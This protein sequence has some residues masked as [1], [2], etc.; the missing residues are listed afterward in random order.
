MNMGEAR[1]FFTKAERIADEHGLHLLARTISSEHD[2]LLE[3][4]EK[5]ETLRKANPPVAERVKFVEIEKTLDHMMGKK[6]LEPPD[7]VEENPILLLIM[8]EGGHTFFNHTFIK[9]WDYSTL[10][11]SFI[12]A[13]NTF[14]S[15]IFEETID[16]IKIGENIIFIKPVEP[17]VVCYV[18]NGQSYPAVKKL[19]NFSK[20]IKN[21]EEI[22]AILNKAAKATQ[23]L[24][25][26]SS[27]LLGAIV[28]EIFK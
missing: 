25:V 28:N 9:D 2:L 16:R 6:M 3:Q 12:S 24:S 22:W 13:F 15:E 17:F 26:S 19:N 14:S 20:L 5:W 23:E 21:R 4:L 11:S 8:S 7:L 27:P 18:S 10:F 1:K